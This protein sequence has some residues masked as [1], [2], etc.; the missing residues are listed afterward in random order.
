MK[1]FSSSFLHFEKYI[2]S[3]ILKNIKAVLFRSIQFLVFAE[4]A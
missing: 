3:A 4:Q 2:N 1:H